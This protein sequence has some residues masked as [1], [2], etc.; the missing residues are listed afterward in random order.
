MKIRPIMK[1]TTQLTKL[2]LIV[3]ILVVCAGITV[4]AQSAVNSIKIEAESGILSSQSVIEAD[5]LASGGSAIKFVASTPP[6]VSSTYLYQNSFDVAADMDRLYKVVHDGAGDFASFNPAHEFEGDHDLN[7]G[8]PTTTRHIDPDGPQNQ[9]PTYRV[10]DLIWYCAPGNE[11]TKGHFMIGL[12]TG[13]YVSVAFSP[14]N[15]TNNGPQI[16]NSP[17]EVCWDINITD[18]AHRKWNELIIAPESVIQALGSNPNIGRFANPDFIANAGFDGVLPYNGTFLFSSIEGNTQYFKNGNG[19]FNDVIDDWNSEIASA[20][21]GNTDKATRYKTCLK[22]N[23][24]NTVTRTQAV[25]GRT[26]SVTGTGSFPTGRVA[27]IFKDV[28]YNVQKAYNEEG[29]TRH[30]SNPFTWHWDNL[31]IK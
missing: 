23:G 20:V 3:M 26:I 15:A 25:P 18:L 8:P 29:A 31:T 28:S 2:H 9:Y 16:F 4:S 21:A 10:Q 19:T 1:K 24:N 14:I 7:C 6:P 30:V 11:P 27:V 12:D 5:T 17:T 13:N 22:D